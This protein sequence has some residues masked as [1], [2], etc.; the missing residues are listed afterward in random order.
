MLPIDDSWRLDPPPVSQILQ[1]S[2]SLRL[3]K[4]VKNSKTGRVHNLTVR[5]I[6]HI[7]VLNG[8]HKWTTLVHELVP[9][10]VKN[11]SYTIVRTTWRR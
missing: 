8:S 1:S 2:Y 4:V 6:S 7:C 11:P 10:P 9:S 5:Q 3:I